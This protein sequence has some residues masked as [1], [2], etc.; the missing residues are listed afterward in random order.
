MLWLLISRYCEFV[1]A[2]V[3]ILQTI[4][5]GSVKREKSKLIRYIAYL[6]A[7]HRRGDKRR[8]ELS[9]QSESHK[10]RRP[11]YVNEFLRLRKDGH[12]ACGW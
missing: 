8:V 4:G 3:E 6:L 7:L 2:S 9:T 5:S 11:S 10:T 1:L 12:S